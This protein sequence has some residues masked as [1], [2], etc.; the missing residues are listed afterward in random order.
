MPLENQIDLLLRSDNHRHREFLFPA[1]VLLIL[2][3]GFC[4]PVSVCEEQKEF[5][6]FRQIGYAFPELFGFL[7]D[8]SVRRH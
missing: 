7:P 5:P 2:P 1:I 3:K 8:S 6:L 4:I